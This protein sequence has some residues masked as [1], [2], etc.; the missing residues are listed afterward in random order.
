MFGRTR[1][2]QATGTARYRD[3][4]LYCCCVHNTQLCPTPRRNIRL[5]LLFST[6]WC[7]VSSGGSD[8]DWRGMFKKRQRKSSVGRPASAQ[9]NYHEGGAENGRP[10]TLGTDTGDRL[11]LRDSSPA[12]DT[13]AQ[14]KRTGTVRRSGSFRMGSL[15]KNRPAIEVVSGSFQNVASITTDGRDSKFRNVDYQ[16]TTDDRSPGFKIERRLHTPSRHGVASVKDDGKGDKKSSAGFFVTEVNAASI[17]ADQQLLQVGD[18]LISVNGLNI[19]AFLD[20]RD[21][22]MLLRGSARLRMTVLPHAS[23]GTAYS[24]GESYSPGQVQR[25]LFP[26][27]VDY[28]SSPQ[29]RHKSN[30]N[31]TGNGVKKQQQQ[32][33]GG[34]DMAGAA[35]AGAAHRNGDTTITTVDGEV[36]ATSEESSSESRA[37]RASKSPES[38]ASTLVDTSGVLVESELKADTDNGR[39]VT[40]RKDTDGRKKSGGLKRRNSVLKSAGIDGESREDASTLSDMATVFIDQAHTI[41]PDQKQTLLAQCLAEEFNLSFFEDS[42]L[43][44]DFGSLGD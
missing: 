16:L 13:K 3:R 24:P 32:G 6:A 7:L 27:V 10:L 44:L 40:P 4:V 29:L 34:R 36:R 43:K 33:K 23:S 1:S 42:P 14:K 2:S 25:E 19:T 37:S 18:E 17:V 39:S 11:S 12:S 21:V 8:R 28:D 31:A 26:D 5:Q 15:R 30:G 35:A 38:N 9:A 41:D 20:V 22:D